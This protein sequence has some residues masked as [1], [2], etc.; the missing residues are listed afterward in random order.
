MFYTN[1]IGNAKDL[2]D[3]GMKM[4]R[5]RATINVVTPLENINQRWANTDPIVCQR[6]NQVS[7]R[8]KYPLLSGHP[9][10]DPHI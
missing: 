3:G 9:R 10:C 5:Q 6:Y 7:R 4:L 1:V 8:S 2:N